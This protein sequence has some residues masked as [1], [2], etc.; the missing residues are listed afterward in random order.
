MANK[1]ITDLPELSAIPDN[2][3]MLEIVDDVAGT[4]TSKKITAGNMRAGL[5]ASGANADI[6]SLNGPALGTPSSGNLSNCIVDDPT[7]DDG[8]MDRG[9]TDQRYTGKEIVAKGPG[10]WFD[11]VD[12]YINCGMDN[13]FITG[14]GEFTILSTFSLLEIGGRVYLF[15]FGN[16]SRGE[17]AGFS[18]DENGYLS[19]SAYIAPI[20]SDTQEVLSTDIF[21]IAAAIYDGSSVQFNLNGK[22][23][24]KIAIALN[25]TTGKASIGT[26]VG[27]Y[28]PFLNGEQYYT[29]LFNLA[30]TATEVLEFSNG[31]PVPYKYIG[32][33]QTVLTSGTL[34]V[35]KHYTID[36]FVA[37]DDF[38]NIDGT[39]ESGTSFVATGTTPT[40]WTN[41]SSLRHTGCVVQYE[42][43]GIG[44]NQWIDKS[45][46]EL[47]GTVSG[48]I[49]INLP[50]DH[51]EKYVDLTLTGNSSYTRPIGYKV[52]SILAK[53]KTGNALT[54][55]LDCGWSANGSEIVSGMA[56]GANAT[57]L[58]T[59]IE[60]GTIGEN[61]TT[62]IDTFYFSDGDDDGNWNGAELK[63]RVNME[64]LVM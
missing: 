51:T 15:T 5:A 37:G 54:G 57:V 1:K 61:I 43:D 6:T 2:T 18:V 21:Y 36:T 42:Q 26:H 39:N 22:N 63:V 27:F 40:T 56:I 23:L 58:C 30:L 34:T 48:A 29:L 8:L 64:R 17:Q 47:H 10:Y 9:Y 60:A 16:D 50:P 35:G 33:S 49:P 19:I 38:T 59:L 52:T 4:P 53:N 24:D 46:N 7:D 11:G 62:A 25:T 44:H 3:D 12:S 55:G 13:N 14:T 28:S 20:V 45:G 32:A 31:A 41:G